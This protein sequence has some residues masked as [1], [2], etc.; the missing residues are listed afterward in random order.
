MVRGRS[1]TCERIRGSISAGLDGELSE[2]DAARVRE[3]L[4]ACDSCRAFNADAGSIAAVLRSAPLEPLPRPISVPSRRRVFPLRTPAAAAAAAVLMVAFGGV[5][6]TLHG[7]AA[8]R[9]SP[10]SGFDN[11]ADIRAIVNRQIERNYE[12]QLVRRAQFQS[13]RIV[14]HPGPQSP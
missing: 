8:I 3:H 2:L 13:N 11:H 7:G 1:Q 4:S 6:E 12:V 14:R 9:T 5:F 10:T